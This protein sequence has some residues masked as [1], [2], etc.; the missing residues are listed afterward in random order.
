MMIKNIGI[1]ACMLA[2]SWTSMAQVHPDLQMVKTIALPVDSALFEAGAKPDS[3]AL[4]AEGRTK[5]FF[6]NKSGLATL[7]LQTAE[8]QVTPIDRDFKLSVLSRMFEKAD[9]MYALKVPGGGDDMMGME[10]AQGGTV[11][12]L[13]TLGDTL[14]MTY[15]F[16]YL[17]KVGSNPIPSINMYLVAYYNGAVV[18][19]TDIDHGIVMSIDMPIYFINP[20]IFHM[21]HPTAAIFG[22]MS[23]MENRPNLFATYEVKKGRLEMVKVLAPVLSKELIN[24][25]RGLTLLGASQLYITPPF[26]GGHFSNEIWTLEKKPKV[27][28]VPAID[29]VELGITM[30]LG[31]PVPPGFAV[32]DVIARD[33]NT[34][35]ALVFEKSQVYLT[36]FD[37]R[38]EALIK[39]IMVLDDSVAS[40]DALPFI[41]LLRNN[42]MLLFDGAEQTFTVYQY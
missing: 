17:K 11:V 37:V 33:N 35:D 42:R 39:R 26:M 9:S 14:Y 32:L 38:K 2:A 12:G 40:L 10:M 25:D 28:K 8:L 1:A 29:A 15:N 27:Y 31:K 21:E 19:V 4:Y 6:V 41:T 30:R 13:A 24:E 23:V 34:A 22:V 18:T 3:P 36:K 16:T 5:F 7:D 20:S